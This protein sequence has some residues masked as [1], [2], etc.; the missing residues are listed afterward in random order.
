MYR[1]LFI[2]SPVDG[3]FDCFQFGALMNNTAMNVQVQVFYGC[4]FSF[5]LNKYLEVDLLGLK[6]SL[7]LSLHDTVKLFPNLAVPCYTP[8]QQCWTDPA[9][10]HPHQQ[11]VLLVFLILAILIGV[12]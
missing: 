2:H 4:I 8:S 6:V 3:H 10:P 11:L 9:A 12:K 7:F 1:D 5:L